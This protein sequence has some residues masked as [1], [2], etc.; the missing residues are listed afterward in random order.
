MVIKLSCL[1]LPQ[2]QP[3]AS[4]GRLPRA[5]AYI[6]D[7]RASQLFTSGSLPANQ[8]RRLLNE[9]ELFSRHPNLEN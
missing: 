7:V 8:H 5:T 6:L 4:V 9:N 2:A 3:V 1:A